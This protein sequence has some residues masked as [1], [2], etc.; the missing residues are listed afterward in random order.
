MT[1]PSWS[2]EIELVLDDAGKPEL[3]SVAEHIRGAIVETGFCSRSRITSGLKE[4]YGPLS[5]ADA[6]LAEAIEEALQLLVLSGDVDEFSTAGGRG[7]S[8]T[9]PRI[10]TLAGRVVALLGGVQTEGKPA[11]VR[12]SAGAISDDAAASIDLADELGRPD[13]RSILV[14]LGGADAPGET[15]AILYNL[16][17][18]MASSG[19]RYSLDEPQA[20]AILSGRGGFFGR[21]DNPP[22]GRW[23]RAVVD[24]CFPAV[25]KSGFTT[26]SV[27]LSVSGKSASLWQPPQLDVW[28]WIV[29]GATLAAGDP[30][31]RY[32][33]GVAKLDFLV[34]PPRQVERAALLTG[35]RVGPWSW[36]IHPSA[37]GV[38]ADLIGQPR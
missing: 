29:V 10:V 34:P 21:P 18:A 36:V 8:P 17:V 15:P 31:L 23:S 32:D 4:A 1:P 9:P 2:N 26:R 12:Q 33:S 14:E 24:G 28:R 16:A 38:I 5:I 13:W 3:Y 11:A 30:V 20:V 6:L 7:Y 22:T 37:F 19:E 35:S 25:I 27:L